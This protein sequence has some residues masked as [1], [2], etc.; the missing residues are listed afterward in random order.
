MW[1]VHL[2]QGNEAC[3]EYV[4]TFTGAPRL[5]AS[6]SRETVSEE[7][8]LAALELMAG[9]AKGWDKLDLVLW[10]TGPYHRA[11]RHVPRGERTAHVEDDGELEP[12]AIEELI[13]RVRQ[14][15]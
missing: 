13:V 9:A 3:L 7:C 12:E 4:L 5:E 14:Q 11:T 15:L 6:A 1:Y 2:R 10:L 8:R